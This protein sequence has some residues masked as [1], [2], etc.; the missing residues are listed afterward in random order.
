M[1]SIPIPKRRTERPKTSNTDII[2]SYATMN[3][4]EYKLLS[5]FYIKVIKIRNR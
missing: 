2:V 4:T 5:S 3:H 1:E